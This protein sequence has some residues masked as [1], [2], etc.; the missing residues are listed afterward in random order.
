MSKFDEL[1]DELTQL[2]SELDPWYDIGKVKWYMVEVYNKGRSSNPEDN[3][4]DIFDDEIK[5]YDDE[6]A[7][8]PQAMKNILK[9][10]DKLKEFEEFFEAS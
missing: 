4:F 9:I 6:H 8:P 5:Y 3:V 1:K 7:I 10:Q 2:V